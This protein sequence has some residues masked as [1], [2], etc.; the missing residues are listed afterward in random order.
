M[1][2]APKRMRRM[3]SRGTASRAVSV[4]ARSAGCGVSWGLL[5]GGDLRMERGGEYD[6][7]HAPDSGRFERRAAFR[8][9]SYRF[10]GVGL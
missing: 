5:V 10:L 2:G 6:Q 7:V 9:W 1:S 3:V 8:A 4:R